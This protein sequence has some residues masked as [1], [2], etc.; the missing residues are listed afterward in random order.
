MELWNL[1]IKH[2]GHSVE[3]VA[4]GD[5]DNPH[6]LCLECKD[7]GSIILDA[8]TETIETRYDILHMRNIPYE[9][10]E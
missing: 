4:D 7:C 5:K 2:V 9:E 10:Q 1:L 3:I 6:N 8:T